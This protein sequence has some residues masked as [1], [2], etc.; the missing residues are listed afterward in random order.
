MGETMTLKDFCGEHRLTGVDFTTAPK[1]DEWVDRDSQVCRFEIDG[2]TWLAVE[3]P[4]DGYRSS[5]REIRESAERPANRWRPVRVVGSMSERGSYGQRDD[6]LEFRLVKT[7]EI[8]LRVG[9][10]NTDDYY[11]SFVA[12][13]RPEALD[14]AARWKVTP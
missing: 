2:K 6:V 11:P 9:T 10:E 5:M 12:D 8:V 1:A 13:F 7:G 4:S 3:D 14:R